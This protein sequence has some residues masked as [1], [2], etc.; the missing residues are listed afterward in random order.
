MPLCCCI[1]C[2]SIDL[3]SYPVLDKSLQWKAVIS[4]ASILSEHHYFVRQIPAYKNFKIVPYNTPNYP[5]ESRVNLAFRKNHSLI[6][7]LTISN[8]EDVRG[9]IVNNKIHVFYT[10]LIQ[11]EVFKV[12]MRMLVLAIAK[13]KSTL[14]STMVAKPNFENIIKLTSNDS[15]VL[16]GGQKQQNMQKNWV[17]FIG[18]DGKVLISYS[19]APTHIV[20]TC[21]YNGTCRTLHETANDQVWQRLYQENKNILR[22]SGGTPC[23]RALSRMLCIGH[24]HT[25]RGRY[26]HFFYEVAPA[27]PY[28][29]LCASRTFRFDIPNTSFH[30]CPDLD[31]SIQMATGMIERSNKL[32]VSFG[33]GDC[34]IAE[35]V[36]DTKNVLASLVG[37][38]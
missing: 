6:P 3:S 31:E 15:V 34:A 16:D 10:Q 33:I 29:I 35:E 8:A 12:V 36:F 23:V 25:P 11:G 18:K 24:F 9:I 26:Y 38:C 22:F 13:I 4:H 20:L 2:G 28:A 21:R 37:R 32:I 27:A 14:I 17:P 5:F 1:A 7:V 30:V 19:I